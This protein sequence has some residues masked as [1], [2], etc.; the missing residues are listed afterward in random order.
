M[1]R[2]RGDTHS[3]VDEDVC[4]HGTWA[5]PLH[6]QPACT[7]QTAPPEPGPKTFLAGTT[8][9]VSQPQPKL[10]SPA[11]Y[12]QGGLGKGGVKARLGRQGLHW[13]EPSLNARCH[14]PV[15]GMGSVAP[16]GSQV[17][18]S[19]AKCCSF[20]V[21]VLSQLHQAFW[22]GL[23]PLRKRTFVPSLCWG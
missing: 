5:A 13:Q 19:D 11:T 18:E 8:S 21:P 14:C 6:S 20:L 4:A 2:G 12:H 23:G 7:D 15:C 1:Y 17:A 9:P 16:S 10:R 3:Y 22:L